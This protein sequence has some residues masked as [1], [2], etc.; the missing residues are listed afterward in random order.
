MPPSTVPEG[1][2]ALETAVIS[3]DLDELDNA[4]ALWSTD[5]ELKKVLTDALVVSCAYLC[6][7]AALHLLARPDIDPNSTSEL[8]EGHEHVPPLVVAVTSYGRSSAENLSIAERLIERGAILDMI[9]KTGWTPLHYAVAQGN[10]TLTRL[11]LEKDANGGNIRHCSPLHLACANGEEAIV[12]LLLSKHADAEAPTEEQM[13]PLHV[14]AAQ[15]YCSIVELLLPQTRSRGMNASCIGGWSPLHLACAGEET[16]LIHSLARAGQ[17]NLSAKG[18]GAA[19]TVDRSQVVNLLLSHGADVN[20]RSNSL[21]KALHLA[22]V[23]GNA[24]MIC[25]LLGREEIYTAAKDHQGNTPLLD[26]V[27]ANQSREIIDLLVPWSHRA[28]QSLPPL[29]KKVTENSYASIIDFSPPHYDSHKTQ[30]TIFDLLYTSQGHNGKVTKPSS[31]EEGS[32]RWIHLP[33]NNMSWCHTLITR[34]FVEGDCRESQV[35]VAMVRAMSQQ[36][37]QG[38]KAHSIHMRP[39]FDMMSEIEKYGDRCSAPAFMYIPYLELDTIQT[40]KAKSDTPLSDAYDSWKANDHRQHRRRTL[41]QFWYKGLDT[42]R[43]D[44]DQVMS[45]YLKSQGTEGLLVVDQLWIW[46]FGEDL[47]ITSFPHVE[48]HRL[49]E[50]SALFTSILERI[51]HGT[52]GLVRN[53][54][55]LA[56]VIIER[57][58]SACDR[59]IRARCNADYFDIFKFSATAVMEAQIKLFREF[60]ETSIA[61]TEWIK[62]SLRKSTAN[63]TE[64]LPFVED[65]LTLRREIDLLV[66]ARDIED[67]LGILKH[68]LDDQTSILQRMQRKSGWVSRVPQTF[69]DLVNQKLD[70][71]QMTEWM[72]GV[73]ASITDLLEH[74]QR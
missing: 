43:R 31:R 60:Q 54:G 35:Y 46:V 67:E 34:W 8:I 73:S 69:E 4:I 68:I 19:T 20:Q 13:R 55:E 25:L 66:E 50:K 7:E 37:H 38:P 39:T 15:G 61:A 18:T 36:Q 16:A 63:P 29:V 72:Q 74:K 30:Q 47:I 28:L 56:G 23:S 58:I 2:S 53:V 40:P 65:L 9:D 21:K 33:A 70:V 41:D 49:I 32:F 51:I 45:R 59:S 3:G 27:E 1:I 10:T 26:A 14:A 17:W 57:C 24:N 71:P 42:D 64:P 6:Q 11:L 48:Q 12:K 52:G 44:G 22:A 62:G 5:R